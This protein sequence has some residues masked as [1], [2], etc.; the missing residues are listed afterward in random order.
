MS[1]AYTYKFIAPAASW[2]MSTAGGVTYTADAL[3]QIT[4]VASDA[5]DLLNSGARYAM[6]ETRKISIS[7]PLP[8]DLV[9]IVNAVTP[10][11]VALTIA[12]Q[13]AGVL[14]AGAEPPPDRTE[15]RP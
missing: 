3:G 9:S 15:P 5:R 10:S 12:A 1:V 11:N 8:A 6:Q 13:P 14:E 2:S 7:S 4:A